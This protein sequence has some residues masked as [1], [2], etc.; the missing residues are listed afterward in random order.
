M[1]GDFALRRGL[2]YA[3]VLIDAETGRRID[4]IPGRTTDAAGNWLRE[5]PGVEVVC[6]DGSEA[7]G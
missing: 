6:R 1:L 5:H 3:T 7:Y 2:V 4:V